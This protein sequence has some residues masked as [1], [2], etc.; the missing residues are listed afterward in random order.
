MTPSHKKVDGLFSLVN[1]VLVEHIMK[2]IDNMLVVNKVCSTSPLEYVKTVLSIWPT[3]K[4]DMSD[5]CSYF[6]IYE[7]VRLTGLPNYMGARIPLNSGLKIDNWKLLLHGNENKHL[8]DLLEFGWPVNYT[9]KKLPSP[10]FSNHIEHEDYSEHINKYI[11]IELKHKALLGPFS[12]DPFTPW[13]QYSP[14]M[15]RAKKSSKDRRIIVNLSHPKGRSVNSGISKGYYLGKQLTYS[16]PTINNIIDKLAYSTSTKYMWSIDLARAYRQLRTDPLSVPLLGI[17]VN[18]KRYFDIAPPFGCRTSSMACARTTDA[19]VKLLRNKGIFTLCYLDDFVGV[20]ETYEDAVYGYKM[21]MKLLDH[22]GLDVAHNKCIEP[23]TK[24]NW[25]GYNIDAQ[26]LIIKIPKDKLDSIILECKTWVIGN[27][28]TRK[29]VQQ[30]AGK[31]NFI[32]KCI[33]PTR[34]FMNRILKFLRE[35]PFKGTCVITEELMA[36]INWFIDFATVFNGK[37]VLPKQE[38][39][40][41]IIECDACLQ[42]GGGHTNTNYYAEKFSDDFINKGMHIAQIEAVNLVAALITLAPLNTHMYDI[43]I[44][45]DNMSAQS[46]F[47]T[48]AGRDPILTACA[49]FIWK[50]AAINNCTITVHHKPG[51]EL[52]LADALSRAFVNKNSQTLATNRCVRYNLSRC[53]VDH[54]EVLSIITC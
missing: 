23:T 31:L 40:Q 4:L 47:A 10:T 14:I 6:K 41:Y 22:L 27:L 53:R 39:L 7:S 44:N 17:I 50:F 33:E 16:L 30:L 12:T 42:G 15:T 21:A 38:K 54:S 29:K 19:V 32:S 24:L 51:I 46:V 13:C 28:T 3:I 25:I 2:N 9:S 5:K 11:N 48:G 26:N 1:S 35:S 45:T 37:I 34:L 8:I 52:T 49:R 43:I 36:D 18:N 20:E